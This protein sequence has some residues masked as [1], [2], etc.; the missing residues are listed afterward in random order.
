[1]T[2]AEKNLHWL[3]TIWAR[4]DTTWKADQFPESTKS[5]AGMIFERKSMLSHYIYLLIACGNESNGSGVK[6]F[7][8]WSKRI[9]PD[10][11]TTCQQMQAI[12]GQFRL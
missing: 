3:V 8:V 11:V 1:M 10:F 2:G 6:F 7:H 5:C 4:W 9:H 12:I